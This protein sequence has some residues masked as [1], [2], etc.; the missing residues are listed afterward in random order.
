[1]NLI[2]NW[3]RIAYKD[4]AKGREEVDMSEYAGRNKIQIVDD[5]FDLKEIV[6]YVE[7]RQPDVVFIDYIQNIKIK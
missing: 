3:Y 2:S 4:L 6:D 5:M 1:M 7:M